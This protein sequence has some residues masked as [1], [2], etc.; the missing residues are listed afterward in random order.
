MKIRIITLF[1]EMFR[2]P[3]SCSIIS[4]AQEKGI[5]DIEYINLRDFGIGPRHQVDDTPYGGGA[6]MIIRADVMAKALERAKENFSLAQTVLLTPQGKVYN[7]ETATNLAEKNEII[8]VCG[9]YEGFDER[10][11]EMVDCEISIGRFILTGGELPAMVIVDSIS[12]L[13][14]GVLGQD[15]SSLSESFSDDHLIEYPQYTRPDKCNGLMVPDLLKSGNHQEISKWRETQSL[16]KS[17]K[18]KEIDG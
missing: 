7:Q 6:G 14:P 4:R 11:R 13:I 18:Y 2:G 9:H 8:L 15:D 1:P 12:R 10:I 5:I 3:L 17:K 16:K